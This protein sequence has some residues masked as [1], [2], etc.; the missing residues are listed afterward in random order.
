MTWRDRVLAPL[1]LVAVVVCGVYAL[2]VGDDRFRLVLCWIVAPSTDLAMFVLS[3]RVTRITTQP[4]ANRRFWRAM[5]GSGLLF[6]TGD[7][8]Q[9]GYVL[10]HPRM[11]VL[12]L[13]PAQSALGLLGVILVCGVGLAHPTSSLWTRGARIRIMLDAA[14][15][16][17]AAG[18]A[19][20]CL[21]T[22]PSMVQSG[23]SGYVAASFGCGL[24][25]IGGFF[26]VKLGLS[27]NSPISLP[28][29]IPLIGSCVVQALGN[30]LLPS[31]SV[32]GVT[33]PALLILVPCLLAVA[34]PR[35]QEIA[36]RSHTD[37]ADRR[38]SNRRR[39]SSWPYLG[40]VV[41]ASALVTVLILQGLRV[42]AWGALIGLLVNV[43]LVVARQ[44]MAL[45]ENN[46]L[47]G[48]LDESLAEIRHRE[49]RQEALLRH[50]SDITAIVGTDGI[51]KYMNPAVERV[52]GG[53]LDE[54]LNRNW[55]DLIHPGDAERIAGQMAEVFAEPGAKATFELRAQHEDESWR[56]LSVVAVNLV[57][58]RGI[59][60]VVMNARDMTEE[61]ELR[62]RLR[63]QA[64]HD[65]LTGLANRRQFTDR[66][67]AAG[68]AEVAVLLVDLNG[69]KQ[70]NDTYGHATG[71]AVLCHVADQ[72]M[73]CTAA[74]DLPARLGGDEFAVLVGSGAEEARAIAERLRSALAQP[75]EI[76]GQRLA[77]GA[78]VG[79]A[80][81]RADQP[82]NLL[83]LADLRMYADKQRSREYAS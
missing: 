73:A 13:H 72:L 29:A 16:Y 33:L 44:M 31:S 74:G 27:G 59:G 61:R 2:D 39:Y 75:A 78:S 10:S 7:L 58:E 5:A 4:P 76:G 11:T 26:A 41:C 22:R 30:A 34:A 19:V 24:L 1:V 66:V 40:T 70:I 69:F 21:L 55:L 77:V 46:T 49:R 62:E 23:A 20:W 53:S 71:D 54:F 79:V 81:G 83:H 42:S 57:E 48:R 60:G 12:D 67:R 3:A 82:D 45:A 15:I 37:G 64:G 14:T 63:F 32:R 65:A 80:A 6:G 25:L 51:V 18:V 43:A 9:L 68:A 36:V 28:A 35:L 56:W 38:A 17:T 47:L 8:I 50:A 52:I